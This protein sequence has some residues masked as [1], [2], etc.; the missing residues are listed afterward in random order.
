MRCDRGADRLGLAHGDRV[1]HAVAAQPLIE[2]GRPESRVHPHG[3]ARR[4]RRRGGPG[5]RARRRTARRRGRCWPALAQ[6]GVQ[7]LAAV[8]AGG[9]QRVVAEP[10][11]CSRSWRPAWRARGPRRWWS[12]RR[13]SSARRRARRPPPTPGQRRLGEPVE[14]ADV[15]EGERAQERPHRGGRHHPVAEHAARSTRQR[16]TSAS[17]MQSPPA[18]IAWTR[19]AAC[20]RG[21][22]R[23]AGRRGR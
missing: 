9:Q 22:P 13:W 21:G 8:G 15:P 1:A 4:W 20:G 19:S 7:H 2:L 11:G 12:P 23:P 14:L 16:N 18:T 3:R 17:S 10:V 5:R 6:P